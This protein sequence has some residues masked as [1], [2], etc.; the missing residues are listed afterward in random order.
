MLQIIEKVSERYNRYMTGLARHRTREVLLRT[1][2]RML[3]DA[4]FSRELL[5]KGVSA[6]PWT[7]ESVNDLPTPINH[8]KQCTQHAIKEL[9]AYS[10]RELHD[11]GITRGTINH[12]V[13]QGRNGID[14]DDRRKVA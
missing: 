3:E 5:E 13:R 4:G 10:D 2:D 11:L 1:S 8:T 6:W 14:H 9:E 7:V 12:A